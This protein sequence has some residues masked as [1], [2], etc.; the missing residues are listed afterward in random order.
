[1]ERIKK[2]WNLNGIIVYVLILRVYV[3]ISANE[4][5]YQWKEMKNNVK[6]KEIKITQMNWTKLK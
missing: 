4:Y 1:M 3:Y 5:Q 6:K 2:L